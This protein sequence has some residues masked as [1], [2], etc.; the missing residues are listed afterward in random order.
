MFV[1]M[2]RLDPQFAETEF[3]TFCTND[4]LSHIV[5]IFPI[6]RSTI[7]LLLSVQGQLCILSPLWDSKCCLSCLV[8]DVSAF[9]LKV[10]IFLQQLQ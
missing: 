3:G 7:L 10:L 6:P 5:V 8:F 9:H 2:Q 4:S 1:F